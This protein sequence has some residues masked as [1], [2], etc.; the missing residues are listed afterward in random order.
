M[1]AWTWVARK[2]YRVDEGESGRVDWASVVGG[3]GHPIG[4]VSPSSLDSLYPPSDLARAW[5]NL[6]HTFHLHHLPLS[7]AEPLSDPYPSIK[8]LI[9]LTHQHHASGAF[10][11]LLLDVCWFHIIPFYSDNTHPL[12]IPFHSPLTLV[13][14]F[15]VIRPL[16][17]GFRDWFP[18]I[19]VTGYCHPP[20]VV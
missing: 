19:T 12:L 3:K 20:V 18:C 16:C 17:F 2:T 9:V 7:V 13:C 5:I 10:D 14:R 6:S 8:G 1:K 4:E 11:H 15:P